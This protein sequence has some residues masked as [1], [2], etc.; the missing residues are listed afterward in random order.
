[1]IQVIKTLEE[2]EALKDNWENLFTQASTATPYQTWHFVMTTWQVW[3]NQMINFISFVIIKVKEKPLMQ[4]FLVILIT[5]LI[6][7]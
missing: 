2:L 7:A 3:H 6:Y 1:M 4:F 5:R